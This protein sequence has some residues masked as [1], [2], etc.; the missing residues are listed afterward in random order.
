MRVSCVTSS[1]I[2]AGAILWP[3]CNETRLWVSLS[4]RICSKKLGFY[5]NYVL[6]KNYTTSL[7]NTILR[8]VLDLLKQPQMLHSE[9]TFKR[10]LCCSRLIRRCNKY[11]TTTFSKLRSW[12]S[13]SPLRVMAQ[14]K[15][16]LHL[17]KFLM[18]KK[19]LNV[20]SRTCAPCTKNGFKWR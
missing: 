7:R 2:L 17:K 13:G 12:R 10:I 6:I 15:M 20:L 5:R 16:Q 3:S 1:A 8:R 11:R 18:L 14:S 19:L 4:C 9:S